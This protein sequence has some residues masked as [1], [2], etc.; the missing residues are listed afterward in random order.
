[1]SNAEILVPVLVAF[2]LGAFLYR[3]TAKERER[4]DAEV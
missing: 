2:L 1:V 4:T 3:V